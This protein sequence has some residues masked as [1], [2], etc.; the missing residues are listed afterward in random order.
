[1]PVSCNLDSAVL[2]NDVVRKILLVFIDDVVAVLCNH[3]TSNHDNT[4][5]QTQT[6]FE[7]HNTDAQ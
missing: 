1:M 4:A 3:S 5:Q 2:L 6:E 7:L